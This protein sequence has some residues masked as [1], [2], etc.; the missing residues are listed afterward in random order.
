MPSLNSFAS[1]RPS[2]TRNIMD[3]K[4][5]SRGRSKSLWHHWPFPQYI[6]GDATSSSKRAAGCGHTNMTLFQKREKTE[7]KLGRY[8]KGV[9]ERMDFPHENKEGGGGGVGMGTTCKRPFLMVVLT[10]GVK[11]VGYAAG[12]VVQ[13]YS[14]EL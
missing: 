1:S 4:L 12:L 2:Q 3:W 8:V 9:F 14:D 11:R 5:V 7:G 6:L 10:N 13:Y